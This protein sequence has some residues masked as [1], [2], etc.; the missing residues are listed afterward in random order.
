MLK[1]QISILCACFI[2]LLQGAKVA[3]QVFTLEPAAGNRCVSVGGGNTIRIQTANSLVAALGPDW[4]LGNGLV[5]VGRGTFGTNQYWIDVRGNNAGTPGA[6]CPASVA[7]IWRVVSP[8]CT[9]GNPYLGSTRVSTIVYKQFTAADLNV[10]SNA[11]G[12]GNFQIFTESPPCVKTGEYVNVSIK[13]YHLCAP[14]PLLSQNATQ[15]QPDETVWTNDAGWPQ[16]YTSADGTSATFLVVG[17]AT[18]VIRCRMGRCN[19]TAQVLA[20]F[21]VEPAA[22]LITAAG[23]A[24][25][26]GTYVVGAAGG[27]PS[28][29]CILQNATGTFTLTATAQAAGTTYN[30]QVPV[31]FTGSSITNTIVLTPLAGTAGASN[32]IKV[33]VGSPASCGLQ[34]ASILINRT[35]ST[36]TANNPIT[37]PS[38]TRTPANLAPAPANLSTSCI[39]RDLTYDFSLSNAPQNNTYIWTPNTGT[40]FYAPTGTSGNGT[41]NYQATI[42]HAA[43]FGAPPA[44]NLTATA[45]GPAAPTAPTQFCTS[46]S[47]LTRWMATQL[48]GANAGATNS[49]RI[50]GTGNTYD[51][52]NNNAT[53][54]SNWMGSTFYTCT[55]QTLG[56]ANFLYEWGFIG[57]FTPS[58]TGVPI[59][60]ESTPLASAANNAA[61]FTTTA[62]TTGANAITRVLGTFSNSPGGTVP[63]IYCRIRKTNAN[64]CTNA[65]NNCFY[66]EL[67]RNP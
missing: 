67:T 28:R 10:V 27:A 40:N 19:A 14:D 52:T 65:A 24:I 45:N 35:L 18:N 48:T 3:A 54:S 30:W 49:L 34:E 63:K 43:F 22:M 31:G 57:T 6:F 61:L 41:A 42:T 13:P 11:D 25:T 64:A 20:P 44:F 23:P 16:V 39:Y 36:T 60:N 58:S 12:L 9:V 32:T 66:V 51:I 29:A 26:S 50:N 53:P 56:A 47:V 15:I 37:N 33:S 17:N 4:Q 59:T 2:L 62:Y 5:E 21:N 1:K 55:G 7:F 8:T 46:T 38:V